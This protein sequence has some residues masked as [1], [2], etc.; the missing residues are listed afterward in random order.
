MQYI[1]TS[2]EMKSY[3]PKTVLADREEDL[4]ALAKIIIEQKLT[5]CSNTSQ[6]YCDN[7]PFRK[8]VDN[9]NVGGFKTPIRHPIDSRLCITGNVIQFS[10]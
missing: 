5:P 3:V 7:C 2:N 9:E 1:L 10:K 6:Y 8:P 4:L